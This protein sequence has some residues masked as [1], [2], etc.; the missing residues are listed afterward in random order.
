MKHYAI[1]L[2]LTTLALAPGCASRQKP[3]VLDRVGPVVVST[4]DSGSNGSLIVYS[5]FDVHAHFND[6]PYRRF[7]SDYQILSD[8]GRLLQRVHNQREGLPGA[9]R[10]WNL[11]RGHIVSWLAPM[12]M[13]R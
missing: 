7:Y 1:I 9:P 4:A 11:R 5:A 8:E 10:Q 2:L 12:D 13:D 3:L 6:L